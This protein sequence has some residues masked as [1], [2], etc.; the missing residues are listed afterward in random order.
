[1]GATI[2]WIEKLLDTP[3]ADYR[4]NAISLVLA[5]YFINIRKYSYEQAYA[6][7]KDWL[8]KCNTIMRLDSNF[9]SRIRSAL[10]VARK[11]GIR[12][13]KNRDVETEK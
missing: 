11:T 10:E 7:I 5:P 13:L 2:P 4:K 1:M 9:D 3:I 8:D 12:P 6:A